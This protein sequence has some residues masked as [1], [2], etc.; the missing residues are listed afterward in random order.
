MSLDPAL[1]AKARAALTSVYGFAA[2]RPGQEEILSAVFDGEDGHLCACCPQVKKVSD[3]NRLWQGLNDGEVSVVSTDTCTF[4]RAQKAT[5]GGD[6][7]KIPMGLP[8]LETLVPLVY[9]RGVLTGRLTLEQLVQKLCVNPAKIMGLYPRKGI[10]APGSDADLVLIDPAARMTVDPAK[11]ET[12]ADWSPYDGWELAG[13]AR[14]TWSRGRKVVD[15]YRFIGEDGWGQW[16][17][18]GRLVG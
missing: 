13:F 16:L 12:N 14:H 2:F 10:I 6:W 18:R 3:Q 8:G 17:P 9:T 5:W 15:E 11:L 7:T 4:S 1:M